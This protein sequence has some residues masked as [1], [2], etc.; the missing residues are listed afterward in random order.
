MY[1][2]KDSFAWYKDKSLHYIYPPETSDLTLLS[3]VP[4]SKKSNV[5][6]NSS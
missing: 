4:Y 3:N 5:E 2:T 6:Y 1:S